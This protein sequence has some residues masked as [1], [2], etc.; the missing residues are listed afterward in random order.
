MVTLKYS[1]SNISLPVAILMS[2]LCLDGLCIYLTCFLNYIPFANFNE[3]TIKEMTIVEIVV[4]FILLALT[5][6]GMRVDKYVR[7]HKY[8]VDGL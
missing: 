6:Q 1:D 7:E 8:D 2:L 4:F 5:A 3:L